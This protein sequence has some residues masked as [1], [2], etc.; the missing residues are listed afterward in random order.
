MQVSTC[1]N[2]VYDLNIH[3]SLSPGLGRNPAFG[4][5]QGFSSKL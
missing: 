1:G 5:G 4:E 3:L 2:H